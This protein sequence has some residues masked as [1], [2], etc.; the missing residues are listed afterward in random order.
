MVIQPVPHSSAQIVDD[1]GK[2]LPPLVRFLDSVRGAVVAQTGGAL[3]G[4]IT[5][6]AVFTGG[7]GVITAVGWSAPLVTAT[8]PTAGSVLSVLGSGDTY[9]GALANASGG[10]ALS[11]I[12]G[13]FTLGSVA[14]AGGFS[15]ELYAAVVITKTTLRLAW[16]LLG[17]S[18]PS[19]ATD[20]SNLTNCVFLGCDSA[21]SYMQIM[22]NDAA[23][24]CT[25]IPL[26]SSF[27]KTAGAFYKLT[28]S[29]EKNGSSVKYTVDR[30]DSTATQAAGTISTNLP[31]NTV[32]MFAA[33]RVG[34]GAAGGVARQGF[35]QALAT[36]TL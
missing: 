29:A 36:V 1:G 17:A 14:N 8:A 20:A 18:A 21:D 33:M 11:S 24:A 30:L 16:G 10:M 23:G 15:L 34:N 26:G 9:T 22:H 7:S 4:T 25:K 19:L 27:P 35:I 32:F 31:A 2:A 12:Y 3:S 13:E 6:C 5:R 28:L